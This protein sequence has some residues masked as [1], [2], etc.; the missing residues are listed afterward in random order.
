[1]LWLKA[2]HVISMVAWFAGLFYLPRLFVYHADAQDKIS[3]ERFIIMERRLFWGIMTPAML[4]TLGTGFTLLYSHIAL[5][6]HEWWM[7]I[8]LICVFCLFVFQ[9]YCGKCVMDFAC[10]RNQHS[11][12][13]Y[14]FINE[15]PTVFLIV[16]VICV[17]VRPF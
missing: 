15:V 3:Y 7:H 6:E 17:E 2:F 5:Y 16:I 11:S 13:F 4:L 9:L 1:M 12:A 10:G 14:R 8:K